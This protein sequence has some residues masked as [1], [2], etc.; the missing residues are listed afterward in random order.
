MRGGQE[1][2]VKKVLSVLLTAAVMLCPFGN[3]AFKAFAESET[4]IIVDNADTGYS[5]EEPT[6]RKWT[7]STYKYSFRGSHEYIDKESN[8]G[9]LFTAKIETG[10]KYSVYVYR[11][12]IGSG[13]S[14]MT[15]TVYSENGS[16]NVGYSLSSG[17]TG[18]YKIGVFVFGDNSDAVIRLCGSGSGIARMDAVKLVPVDETP[19][20]ITEVTPSENAVVSIKVQP[21]I[22]FSKQIAASFLT[23]E[24]ILLYC[25][26]KTISADIEATDGGKG[27]RIIPNRPLDIR[28]AYRIVVSA[29]LEDEDG[30][31]I[32]G[33][34][35]YS[36]RT[37]N[38]D[39]TPAN[40][41]LVDGA[42]LL[43]KYARLYIAFDSEMND[44]I[45]R[46][47][48]YS[49]SDGK[50]IIPLCAEKTNYKSAD[51]M[52]TPLC[53]LK[54]NGEYTLRLSP[55]IKTRDGGNLASGRCFSV[56]VDDGAES[57]SAS[58]E[59]NYGVSATEPITVSFDGE[60]DTA[61]VDSEHIALKLLSRNEYVEAAVEN[62]GSYA[63]IKP[64]GELARGCD[65]AI[66]LHNV[67]GAD[68]K[69]ISRGDNLIFKTEA[70]DTVISDM[71]TEGSGY[72]DYG[73]WGTSSLTGYEGSKTRYAGKVDNP[74]ETYAVW[75][76]ALKG[77]MYEVLIY[78]IYDEASTPEAEIEILG[79]NGKSTQIIPLT[80]F[81]ESG[82]YSLGEYEF[83]TGSEGYVKL[84]KLYSDNNLRADAV[85][86]RAAAED[87]V[88]PKGKIEN[89]SGALALEFD[90]R[91]SQ[92]S[93]N[94]DIDGESAK[95]I[96]SDFKSFILVTDKYIG[97]KNSYSVKITDEI[98]APGT[99]S[100][101][102]ISAQLNISS[103][104]SPVVTVYTDADGNESETPAAGGKAA[105][106]C[107]IRDDE[108]NLA[109]TEISLYALNSDKEVI[110]ESRG[111]YKTYAEGFAEF[112]AQLDIESSDIYDVCAFMFD[113][114]EK[115]SLL[116]Q[117]A[118]KNAVSLEK[119]ENADKSV[120]FKISADCE[121]ENAVLAIYNKNSGGLAAADY[122]ILS[123]SYDYTFVPSASF[124]GGEYI[125]RVNAESGKEYAQTDFY[126]ISSAE[127][128]NA[129]AA[130][131]G[132]ENADAV[133]AAI[134]RYYRELGL[135]ESAEEIFSEL[136]DKTDVCTVILNNKEYSEKN[137][138]VLAKLFSEATAVAAVN[139]LNDFGKYFNLWEEFFGIDAEKYNSLVS[140]T[141]MNEIFSSKRPFTDAEAVKK[142][143]NASIPLA[144]INQSA[145]GAIENII[146]ENAGVLEITLDSYKKL[147]KS[148]R[149]SVLR[150]IS[151][152]G[153]KTTESFKKAFDA[154]VSG[155]SSNGGSNT[156]GGGGGGSVSVPKVKNEN[157]KIEGGASEQTPDKEKYY[158]FSD[159][160]ETPWAEKAILSLYEK[161][162]VNGYGDKSFRP[163]GYV[164]RE[165]FVKMITEAFSIKGEAQL[166]FSDVNKNEWYS[167][168]IERAYSNGI[169]TGISPE[170]FGTGSFITRQD[171]A[172]IIDRTAEKCNIVLDEKTAQA[173]FYDAADIAMYAE[174][175]VSR[176]QKAG[177]MSGTAEHEF[178]PAAYTT[179]AMA[180][181]IIYELLMLTEEVK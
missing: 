124:P 34:L 118:K 138:D 41:Q 109:D 146:E 83:K 70:A 100:A 66:E 93:L 133:G 114:A 46:S 119:T 129:F 62:H 58:L 173:D 12:H 86:F 181:K 23:N 84:T 112:E 17:S 92:A 13:N 25:G 1:V 139:R 117:L 134:E 137:S 79:A 3:V 167:P 67:R 110:A 96:S 126:H 7:K 14:A 145:Y 107:R 38:I 154:A 97:D 177:I 136:R 142:A 24:Y 40:A 81:D 80:G 44:Y 85:M 8:I 170:S 140:K 128:E 175:A 98:A 162:I 28:S 158:G 76:P 102:V 157:A 53:P 2:I 88:P 15:A 52:L 32:S 89:R 16:E 148:E 91:I 169:I 105:A 176:L 111:K 57:I 103:G 9:A 6:N 143:Y 180:A 95:F 47:D 131:N 48:C 171:A 82:W 106:F 130:L 71:E 161:S 132:A 125:I 4:E 19:P 26:E 68:G 69:C 90:K 21:E 54:E 153:F 174:G 166:L 60:T 56:T 73:G 155:A 172:V 31:K 65:Y 37:Q 123:G 51:V 49:L 39:L 50:D 20:V 5:R 179:R 45:Y 10:G 30:N 63:L 18:W 108:G 121:N 59:N 33:R 152:K 42:S 72:K 120:Q 43:P 178:A 29:D 115:L 99:E 141:N 144:L 156:G 149:Q 104:F 35:E 113:D 122:F 87:C 77:G 55:K 160:S 61:T 164:T 150:T 151:G 147:T 74:S 11:P 168:Y 22:T 75:Q 64:F 165:E 36:F 27:V 163:N 78:R 94:V 159:L 116:T 101:T 135:D 127:V